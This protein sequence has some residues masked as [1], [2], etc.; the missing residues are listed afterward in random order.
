[1][2]K[3]SAFA[4]DWW[5][6]SQSIRTEGEIPFLLRFHKVSEEP[7][8][9]KI[10]ENAKHLNQLGMNPNRIAVHLKVDHKHV[11]RALRWLAG[12]PIY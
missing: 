6:R 7:T 3:W 8:Y 5:T 2:N 1:M 9:K 11:E 4:G 10:A 12:N